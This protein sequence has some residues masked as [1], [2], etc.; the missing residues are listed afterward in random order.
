MISRGM[1]A[2]AAEMVGE[3]FV[4]LTRVFLSENFLQAARDAKSARV[5]VPYSLRRRRMVVKDTLELGEVL[6]DD[7]GDCSS[8]GAQR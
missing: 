7:G 5:Y 1:Y 6:L 4:E 8:R 2:P 3:C